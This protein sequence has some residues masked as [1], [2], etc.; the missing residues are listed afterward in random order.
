MTYCS[1]FKIVDAARHL[2]NGEVVAYPTEA[3]YGLGCDPLN[4]Q[5]VRRILEIKQ[6]SMDKG[7][8]LIAGSI[9]Q[10]ESYLELNQTIL[11]KVTPTWPGPTTW[12]IPCQ[13][14]VPYWLTGAH[15]SLAVRVSAHPIVQRLCKQFNGPIVSTSANISSK[16]A[17]KKARDI[18]AAIPKQKIHILAGG[19]GNSSKETAIYHAITGQRLR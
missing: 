7:L 14:W 15:D 16:P 10:L 11:D 2:K 5:A 12:V 3:V 13:D 4:E 8:I 18:P 1:T 6:R 9:E 17:A 19:L